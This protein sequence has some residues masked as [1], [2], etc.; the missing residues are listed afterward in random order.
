M[1]GPKSKQTLNANGS[2]HHR[3]L[4]D[5]MQGDRAARLAAGMI[6]YVV[7]PIRVDALVEALLQATRIHGH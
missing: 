5:R 3:E 1:P 7:Q 6:D 4:V 2:L